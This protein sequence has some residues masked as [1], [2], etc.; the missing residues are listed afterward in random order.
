MLTVADL[1]QPE[2]GKL[3]VRRDAVS[4]VVGVGLGGQALHAPAQAMARM[5][6]NTGIVLKAGPQAP[7]Y[8]APGAWVLWGDGAAT[9]LA[10]GGDRQAVLL[11]S[12]YI[13]AWVPAADAKALAEVAGL[14]LSSEDLL[15]FLQ[16]PPGSYLVERR[17]MPVIRGRIIIP[18]GVNLHTRS[19]EAEISA[20]GPGTDGPFAL[21]DGV[22]LAGNVSKSFW[23]GRR[24][25]WVCLPGQIPA[26]L[27]AEP[28]AGLEAGEGAGPGMQD[29]H[30]SLDHDIALDEGDLRQPR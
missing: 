26:R 4:D 5:R 7:S 14:D 2:W 11:D 27:L 15:P 29:F 9:E 19:S 18:D 3:L 13:L 10:M 25:L 24:R 1:L 20:V 30:L 21:G 23:V 16:A 12:Q 6:P 28:E 22:F 8:Y 17:E